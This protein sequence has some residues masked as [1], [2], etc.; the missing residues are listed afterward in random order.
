MRITGQVHSFETCGTVDGPG[1]RFVLFLQGCPLRCLYC[2]NPDTWEIG[3]GQ[4]YSVEEIIKRVKRNQPYFLSSGG[5]I[6]VSGGEPGLQ[7]QFVAELFKQCKKAGI[8]TALDTSGCT[9]IDKLFPV[10]DW[11]DL[12][13]LD[14]K[15]A[16][17]EKHRQLTGQTNTKNIELADY[18]NL[19]KIRFW[20]RYV[21]VPGYTDGEKDLEQL[22]IILARLESLERLEL[23]PYHRLGLHKWEAL[24]IP[25]QLTSVLPPSAQQIE[26]VKEFLRPFT[27]AEIA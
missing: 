7:P 23:I 17:S 26:R 6:T 4:E 20:L 3:K 16:N 14:L 13:I 10:L 18:L 21:I 24:G 2:H 15:H 12:V 8:H 1:L 22:G 5:G 27:K 11:T 9:G 19:N 25:N